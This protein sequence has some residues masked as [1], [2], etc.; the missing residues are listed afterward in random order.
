MGMNHFRS[1]ATQILA[2]PREP[3]N[4]L[5]RLARALVPTHADFCFVHLIDRQHLRCAASAHATREGRRLVTGLARC[6]RILITDPFSTVA[7]VVRSCRPQLRTEIAPDPDPLP[8]VR[9]LDLLRQLAPRSAIVVPLLAN[10]DPVGAL[11]LGYANSGR[12]YTTHD[13]PHAKWLARQITTYLVKGA[14]PS[15]P[16]TRRL[17]P[18]RGR[19]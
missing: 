15:P 13:V 8:R 18:L 10:R 16:A 14:A 2:S 5:K 17:P 7:Q 11:T 1:L 3:S 6:D 19:A 12:Q 4:V 9:V